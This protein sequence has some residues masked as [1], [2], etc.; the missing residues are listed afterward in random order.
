MACYAIHQYILETSIWSHR[1]IKVE[2]H[3]IILLPLTQREECRLMIF[4]NRVLRRIFG[5]K[6]EDVKG[7]WGKF[8]NDK[9]HILG[10]LPI[11]MENEMDWTHSMPVRQTY[12]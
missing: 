12:I 1:P 10:C 2:I 7:E 5:S 11:Y 3:K 4:E 6:R 9:L 8:H